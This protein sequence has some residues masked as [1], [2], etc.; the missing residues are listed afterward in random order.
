MR[1]TLAFL[2]GVV[3][4]VGGLVFLQHPNSLTIFSGL[5][6]SNQQPPEIVAPSIGCE[7]AWLCLESKRRR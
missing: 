7:P 2:L 3:A 5:F 4:G 1:I 6:R